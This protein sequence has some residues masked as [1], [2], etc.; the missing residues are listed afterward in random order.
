MPSQGSAEQG[1][2]PK[3]EVSIEV[4][5]KDGIDPKIIDIA[6]QFRGRKVG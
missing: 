5:S 1:I 2:A 4:E 3:G 6:R